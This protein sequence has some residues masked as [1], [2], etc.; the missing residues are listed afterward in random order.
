VIRLEFDNLARLTRGDEVLSHELTTTIAA[1]ALDAAGRHGGSWHRA[2]VG[3]AAILVR[4]DR[5]E[6]KSMMGEV[7]E[8]ARAVIADVKA[9]FPDLDMY[10]GV[11]GSYQGISGLRTSAAEAGA[12]ATAARAAKQP[13]R[14]FAYFGLG[15]RR[16]LL[17][18]YA[19]EGSRAM[20]D[21]LLESIDRLGPRK[22]REAIR[23]LEA[24]LNHPH[25]PGRAAAELGL[26]RNTVAY[27]V[28][29]L[30]EFLELDPEDPE[31][32]LMLQLACRVRSL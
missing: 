12:G 4:A 17:Q 2:A 28:R 29:R 18:F 27:R 25:S 14:P 30:F 21:H 24:F 7:T 11:G 15:F 22:S 16:M 26:H 1:R 23:T 8:V 5:T 9:K 19:L 20:I 10:C 31:H 32:R 13:D 6:P 3:S